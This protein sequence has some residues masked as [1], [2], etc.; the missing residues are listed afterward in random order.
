MGVLTPGPGPAKN[1]REVGCGLWVDPLN[2][3]VFVTKTRKYRQIR[4]ACFPQPVVT[5]RVMAFESQNKLPYGR[6]TVLAGDSDAIA[7]I[8]LSVESP[9][10]FFI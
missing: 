5:Q 2:A 9:A 10:A 1:V 6:V 7:M 3:L 4:T 8:F